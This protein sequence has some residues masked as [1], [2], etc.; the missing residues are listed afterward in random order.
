MKKGILLI[1]LQSTIFCLIG[2]STPQKPMPS[3]PTLVE[4]ENKIDVGIVYEFNDGVSLVNEYL[5]PSFGNWT[6]IIVKDKTQKAMIHDIIKSHLPYSKSTPPKIVTIDEYANEL[7]SSK[8]IKIYGTTKA[9]I[10]E[11][12]KDLLTHPAV[13]FRYLNK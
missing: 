3:I 7:S 2:C 4:K 13:I 6:L 5:D 12:R 10:S 9:I 11:I 1:V 8:D